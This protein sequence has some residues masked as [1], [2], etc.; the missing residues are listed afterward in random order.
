MG[1]ICYQNSTR[2]VTTPIQ[3]KKNKS[4]PVEI[5]Y[6]PSGTEAFSTIYGHYGSRKVL[7]SCKRQRLLRLGIFVEFRTVDEP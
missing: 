2:L 4:R 6:R 7:A 3:A 5:G 1:F